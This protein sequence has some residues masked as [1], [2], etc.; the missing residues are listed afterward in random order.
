MSWKDDKKQLN[1]FMDATEYE[2]L[3]N[4]AWANRS[5]L[6]AYVRKLLQTHMAQEITDGGTTYR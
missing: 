6:S 1:F 4:L 5:T 2:K 3:S